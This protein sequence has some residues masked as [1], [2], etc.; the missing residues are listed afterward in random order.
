MDITL[1]DTIDASMD[2]TTLKVVNSSFP[3]YTTI[4]GQAVMFFFENIWLPDSLS[5]ESDSHGFVTYEIS[6][7]NGMADFTEVK[8]EANII[9]DFN[10]PILTNET[11]NTFVEE[12]CNDRFFEIDTVIC[13]GT[14]YAG[15]TA[16][17]VYLSLIHI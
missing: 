14:S 1:L 4:D 7:I 3:V 12:I 16:T 2:L 11:L 15:Y 6:P 5:N 8:N 17:G 10:D 9:F 13:D